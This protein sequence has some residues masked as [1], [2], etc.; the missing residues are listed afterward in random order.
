MLLRFECSSSSPGQLCV[1]ISIHSVKAWRGSQV[2]CVVALTLDPSRHAFNHPAALGGARDWTQID[3]DESPFTF[4][5]SWPL[6]TSK[7]AA[8]SS[9]GGSSVRLWA[10]R[11]EF[12]MVRSE[13]VQLP[14]H[15]THMKHEWKP[16]QSSSK[17][18]L[19]LCSFCL[20]SARGFKQKKKTPTMQLFPL[21]FLPAETNNS[22]GCWWDL[23][24]AAETRF[25]RFLALTYILN[26]WVEVCMMLV[27]LSS[28]AFIKCY[29]HPRDS[30]TCLVETHKMMLQSHKQRCKM[31]FPWLL[32]DKKKKP[33][34]FC[35]SLI[36]QQSHRADF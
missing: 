34:Y 23:E 14:Q 17:E 24:T 10:T 13:R 21:G 30:G 1:P 19:Y 12:Q 18:R 25:S 2:V 29:S 35:I 5:Q 8:P 36:R 28:A 9:P 6:A 31:C 4:Q 27:C 22:T 15:T 32:L 3:S 33:V 16:P 7:H 26:T 20:W 11:A